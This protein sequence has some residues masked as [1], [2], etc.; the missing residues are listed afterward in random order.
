MDSGV[1]DLA[2]ADLKA[3]PGDDFFRYANGAWLDQV[4]IPA[5]KPAYSLRLAMTDKTEERLHQLIEAVAAK[6]GHQPATT[7]G[8]VGAFYKSFMNEAAVEKAGAIPLKDQIAEICGAR[9]T[10]EALT[11]LMG[12]HNADLF[13]TIFSIG[14]D[15]DIADPTPLRSLSRAGGTR[16][17]GPRLLSQSRISLRKKRNIRPMSGSFLSCWN[18][19]RR[20][21]ARATSSISRRRSRRFPGP[22]RSSATRSQPTTPCRSRSWKRSRPN[23]SWRPFLTEAGLGNV[24]RVVV[25]EKSAFPKIAK[26]FAETP[27]DVLQAWQ[28]FAV[29]DHAAPYL[30]KPFA[31]AAFEMRK[32]T[33]SGQAQQQVRWKRAVHAVSGDDTARASA[34]IALAT[35]DGR[36]VNFTPQNIFHR[37]RRRRSKNSSPT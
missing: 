33:L 18:G 21:R 2:G 20:K 24:E 5:D 15:V 13:G 29:A 19:P 4:Q 22:A 12:R 25:A 26:V 27:V 23:F 16:T 10:R 1:F 28:T 32:K 3:K 8:K 17:A 6:A 11:T 31:D 30:A 9:K 7:A 36:W 14:I 37:K 35:S 34:P